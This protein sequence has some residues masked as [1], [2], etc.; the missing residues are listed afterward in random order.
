MVI[1]VGFTCAS[2]RNFLHSY[3]SGELFLTL[4]WKQIKLGSV[5]SEAKDK[6]RFGLLSINFSAN[7]E[8]ICTLEQIRGTENVTRTIILGQ[9]PIMRPNYPICEGSG[10]ICHRNFICTEYQLRFNYLFTLIADRLNSNISVSSW[11][12]SDMV[13]K[14]LPIY[15]SHDVAI[16]VGCL[17]FGFWL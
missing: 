8:I 4:A 11:D 13:K 3:L 10:G 1:F 7:W 14:V 5:D 9:I 15:V 17:N 2:W 16:K 6:K 12:I